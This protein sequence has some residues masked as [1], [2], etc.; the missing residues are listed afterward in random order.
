M[1]CLKYLFFPLLVILLGNFSFARED[2]RAQQ[3]GA[4]YFETTFFPVYV[5]RNDTSSVTTSPGVASESGLGYDFRNTL[6]YVFWNQLL[7]G[8]SYDIYRLTT[9]RANVSGGDEG[10]D[11][12][13]QKSEWG[14][15][16][17]Y[18]GQNWRVLYMYFLSGEK[19]VDTK[20]SDD[21][22]A[23]G[24][25]TITNTAMTGFQL[26][27]GYSFRLWEMVEIGPSLVYRNVKYDKQSKVNRLNS[28][29]NYENVTLYSAAIDGS[30]SVMASLIARF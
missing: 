29:E 11:E 23:T 1:V 20:N 13:T 30:L 25:K 17:G 27:L 18:L 10:L 28:A 12:T 22:G 19:K 21:S 8:M 26:T 24:D 5:L 2:S 3:S 4:I 14:P 15:T 16:L 9:N 7:V 6:G